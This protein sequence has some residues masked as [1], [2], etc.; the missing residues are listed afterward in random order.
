MKKGF[1]ILFAIFQFA[2]LHAQHNEIG[3]L[4]GSSYYL[5]DLNPSKHFSLAKP[6]GGL[7]YRHSFDQRWAIK[8]SGLCGSVAG[9]DAK[10]KFNESRNLS[11][12]SPIYEV[13]SQL[14]LNF[15]PY[16]TGN[17]KKDYFTPYIFG[18]ISIFSFNPKAKYNGSWYNLQPLGTE[19]QGTASLGTKQY[20]LLN[21]SFPFGLGFKYS[22]GKNLCI[23]AEWGLRKT[24][25][26]YLDD[27]STTYAA[28]A[29]L[30]SRMSVVLADRSGTD[31]N[32]GLQRGNSG[33]KDWYS[34]AGAFITFAFKAS[35][36]GICPAYK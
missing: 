30:N 35:G 12:K 10:T 20:S 24:T 31:D 23:G 15:L 16:A 21:V 36:K 1:L 32:T 3:L 17:I 26:D 5:G 2:L 27:V 6:A 33:T 9:D 19:G 7:I 22:I 29:T 14:E 34:F 28:P 13:S 4:L 11:F 25:T 8:M 18:G